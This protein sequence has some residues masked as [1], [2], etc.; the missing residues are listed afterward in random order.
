MLHIN[1]CALKSYFEHED[2]AN[3]AV[4]PWEE[5]Y[6]FTTVR[7]PWKKMVSYYFFYR[8]D[9]DF[10]QFLV[11]KRDSRVLNPD[12][13]TKSQ[14]HHG[15]NVW[16]KH[17]MDGKGLP[18][19]DYFC[20]DHNNGELLLDDVFKIEEI[21]EKLPPMLSRRMGIEIDKVPRLNPDYGIPH[22]STT[23][24]NWKGD[25]YSLYDEE[26]RDIVSMVYKSDIENFN[27]KFGE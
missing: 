21:N 15:F 9:K 19:Y 18:H 7:N 1:A 17:V 5:Y 23:Y 13:D 20:C 8:P 10:N 2:Y 25:Y 26:S 11:M 12:Y 27:Y 6:K 16:L 24:A 4:G 14:F 22:Q 3:K